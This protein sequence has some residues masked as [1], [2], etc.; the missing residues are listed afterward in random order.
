M[1][2]M[3]E[4]ERRRDEAAATAERLDKMASLVREVGEDGLSELLALLNETQPNGSNGYAKPAK[5]SEPR[6]REAVRRIVARR[7]GLW[8][9]AEIR[10]EM[11]REGWFTTANGLD[12]AVKRLCDSGEARRGDGRGQYVFPANHGEVEDESGQDGA[13]TLARHS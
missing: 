10:V 9:L 1:G 7:P 3:A 11:E 12:A 4:L 13:A 5:S 6:G 2:V 8:T